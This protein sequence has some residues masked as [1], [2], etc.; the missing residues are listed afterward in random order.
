MPKLLPISDGI[1]TWDFR[2]IEAYDTPPAISLPTT[3]AYWEKPLSPTERA[4]EF[5]CDASGNKK[6]GFAIGYDITKGIGVNRKDLVNSAWYF[7]TSR[8]MYPRGIDDKLGNVAANTWYSCFGYRILFDAE[9]PDM[10]S[11]STFYHY[12]LGKDVIIVFDYH[13]T[14]SFDNLKLPSEYTGRS[15]SVVEKSVNVTIHT[16]EVMQDGITVSVGAGAYAYCVL[17]LS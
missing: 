5:L 9:N 14:V 4:V 8:K 6:V 15:V 3:S 1:K 16:T 17:K 11:A 10:G 12:E 7:Y 13:T 2:N